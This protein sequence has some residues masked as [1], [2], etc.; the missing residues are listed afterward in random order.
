[1]KVIISIVLITLLAPASYA[2]SPADVAAAARLIQQTAKMLEK[3]AAAGIE[4]EAPE[5]RADAEGKYVSP[6]MS[7][8][9]RTAWADKALQA[10]VGSAAGKEAGKKAAGMLAKKVPFGGLM[11]K[12][13]TDKAG[14]QGAVMAA[15]G[16]EFIRENSDLSFDNADNTAVYL[17][18]THA[19]TAGYEEALSAAF[20]IYPDL[21]KRYSGAI[22]KAQQ[23]ARKAQKKK[24]K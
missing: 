2:A 20:D 1:M 16:W 17:H 12:K 14:S 5:P 22:K 7:S 9:D 21:K 19:G 18:V 15:G 6:Y 24:K 3:Y 10:S 11:G 8:G 13:V 4:L 23:E